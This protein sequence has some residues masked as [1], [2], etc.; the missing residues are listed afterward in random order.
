M[1]K[2]EHFLSECWVHWSFF[3]SLFFPFQLRLIPTP[4][5][6]SLSAIPLSPLNPTPKKFFHLNAPSHHPNDF[7]VLAFFHALHA[8]LRIPI[9]PPLHISSTPMVPGTPIL[10]YSPPFPPQSHSPQKRGESS[11]V[12]D[13]YIYIFF[14]IHGDK[15]GGLG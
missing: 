8:D 2:R 10:L 15:K 9:P 1:N 13:I 11:D 12:F 6:F 3:K 4:L 14:L 5:L 7:Q